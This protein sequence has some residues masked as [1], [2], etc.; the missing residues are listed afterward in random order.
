[1]SKTLQHILEQQPIEASAP[2]RID[3]AGTLDLA[4]F[5]YPLQYFD[6][7]TVNL[8]IDLR[9]HVRLLPYRQGWIKVSSRGFESAAFPSGHTYH[10]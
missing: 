2:C 6:P 10:D 9:T 5:F 1:M 3:M 7:C 4:T 8:A